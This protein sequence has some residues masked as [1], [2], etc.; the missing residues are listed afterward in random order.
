ATGPIADSTLDASKPPSCPECSP[1]TPSPAR[2]LSRTSSATTTHEDETMETTDRRTRPHPQRTA[3]IRNWST[4]FGVPDRAPGG[5]QS[6]DSP[7]GERENP[8]GSG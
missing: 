5:R 6:T 2:P 8:H 4:L 3:P 7:A 1:P